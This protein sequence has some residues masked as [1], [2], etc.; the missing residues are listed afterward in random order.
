MTKRPDRNEPPVGTAKEA[1][2][3]FMLAFKSYVDAVISASLAKHGIS[4][5]TSEAPRSL[6]SVPS[7]WVYF[8][9]GE[10]GGPIKIGV[11]N[12]PTK[13]LAELQRTSPVRLE[14]IAKVP[15][16]ESDEKR[17][18][19]RFNDLR[20]HGEWFEPAESLMEFLSELG[21]AA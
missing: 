15:G 4:A 19:M 10:D 9:Q 2:L 21:D 20:L 12:N 7:R 8:I 11:A 18:H 6:R 16:D 1:E 3:A 14:I 13:R 17:L 5:E